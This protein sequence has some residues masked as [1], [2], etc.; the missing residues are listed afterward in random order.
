MKLLLV[1]DEPRITSF[2]AK[3]LELNG[4]DVESVSTGEDALLRVG[5]ADLD[6]MILDLGL[7]DID[8]LDVM[9]RLRSSGISL[10]IVILTARADVDDRVRGLD[11]GANDYVV[12]PFALDELLA[13]IRACLRD[14]PAQGEYRVVTPDPP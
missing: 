1:E 2:L 13:R 14:R 11:L 7:P 5:E 9:E 4:Y 12:K 3:G 6:L 8:G 10:P